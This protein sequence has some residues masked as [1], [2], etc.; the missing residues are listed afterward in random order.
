MEKC[1]PVII[2]CINRV[3]ETVKKEEWTLV[4]SRGWRAW[5]T[6]S[7]KSKK[8]IRICQGKWDTHEN[9]LELRRIQSTESLTQLATWSL[10]YW[11]SFSVNSSPFFGG[12][13]KSVMAFAVV[14]LNKFITR[15]LH[16]FPVAR[17]VSVFGHTE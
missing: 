15:L 4:I 13:Q 1:I 10:L 17:F 7:E 6:A 11:P 9:R 8:H 5:P 14:K 3:I 2:Q 12:I 16:S